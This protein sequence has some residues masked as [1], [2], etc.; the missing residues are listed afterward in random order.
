MGVTNFANNI[1]GFVGPLIVAALTQDGVG[2][3]DNATKERPIGNDYYASL[4]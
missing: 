2:S 1:G 3:N 4:V